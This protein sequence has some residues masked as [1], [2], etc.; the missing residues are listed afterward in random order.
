M[1]TKFIPNPAGIAAV[2]RSPAVGAVMLEVAQGVAAFAIESAPVGPGEVEGHYRDQIAAS[3]PGVIGGKVGAR[4]NA[5]KFT[6][7]WIEKGTSDTPAFHVLANAV[8][9]AGLE[10]GSDGG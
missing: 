7:G 10:L 5:N 9:A 3:G 8:A 1:A 6:S 2:T 4:V